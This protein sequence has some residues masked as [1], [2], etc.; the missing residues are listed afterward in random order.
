MILG[1]DPS[2]KTGLALISII[3]ADKGLI[4]IE[5]LLLMEVQKKKMNDEEFYYLL[6]TK[7]NEFIDYVKADVNDVG[8]ESSMVTFGRG[9]KTIEK[10]TGIKTILRAVLGKYQLPTSLYM[11]STVKKRIGGSGKADKK[12]MIESVRKLTD[13]KEFKDIL[14]DDNIADALA[15]AIT[16]GIVKHG[17]KNPTE[18]LLF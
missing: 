1:I 8:M 4:K 16:H 18:N 5:N 6:F 10:M 12:K 15:I 17:L 11:P 13:D 14:K 7:F 2:S 9:G 3:D